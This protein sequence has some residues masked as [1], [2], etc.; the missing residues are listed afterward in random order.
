MK[1][2]CH[3]LNFMERNS[4]EFLFKNVLT[5][6]FFWFPL[7]GLIL[8]MP[9]FLIYGTYGFDYFGVWGLVFTALV[10]F[11]ILSLS[12]KYLS[13]NIIIRFLPKQL[14]IEINGNKATYN[15]EDVLGIFAHDYVN[16]NTSLISFQISFKSGKKIEII[17]SKF[18]EKYEVNENTKLKQF[19]VTFQQ[20]LGFV[21]IGK[22]RKRSFQKLGATWFAQ[23]N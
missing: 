3:P 13:K 7:G 17:D 9:L 23:V 5:L 19:L 14:E 2:I 16:N 15:K 4:Q 11:I 20:E 1:K 6:P 22:S 18:T 8:G 21:K 10:I 12:I